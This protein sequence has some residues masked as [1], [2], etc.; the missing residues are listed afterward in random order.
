MYKATA[1]DSD[2][3]QHNTVEMHTFP[4]EFIVYHSLSIT[5]S[6]VNITI[7]ANMRSYTIKN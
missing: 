6:E 7:P 2:V 5:Y 3:S 4:D 1:I